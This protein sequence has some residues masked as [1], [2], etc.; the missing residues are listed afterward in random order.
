MAALIPHSSMPGIISP[1][2]PSQA[3]A[4]ALAM[5]YQL[6]QSQ[7]WP[8]QRVLEQQCLQMQSLFRHAWHTVPFYRQRLEQAGIGPETPLDPEVIRRIPVLSRSEVQQAGQAM[9]SSALPAAHGESRPVQTSG[10]TGRPVRLAGTRL[11]EFFWLAFTLRDHL[12]HKRD[13]SLKLAAIRFIKDNKAMAPRGLARKGWGPSTDTVF[14]TGPSALLNVSSNLG[15]QLAWLTEQKP[16]YLLTFPTN[17]LALARRCS[18]EGRVL[19]TLREV[20][21]VGE[22][23]SDSLRQAC[24]QAWDVPLVDFYTSNEAGYLALQCPGHSHYHVQAENVYLE[25]I[26]ADGRPCEPGETGQVVITN[27]NN[28]A[29]PLIRYALG[30]QAR[31]GRACPCGRGLPVIEEILGRQ[32]N[33]LVLPDGETHWPS[34]GYYRFDEIADIRQFQ[35]VQLNTRQVEV[36][37]VTASPLGP[38]Q[39][40]Q[41]KQVI[42][43]HLGYP[44][45]ILLVYRDEIPRGPGGKYEEFISRVADA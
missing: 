2:I 25:I 34:F 7:W 36:R 18:A 17:L 20:R 29:T 23:V 6:E 31:P 26:N 30:D 40:E 22:P 37:L 5:Q 24:R 28:F 44:F 43:E 3:G 9:H 16:G 14:R 41:L 4:M 8:P 1:A 45:E 15:E 10:S 12:W 11:T 39:E 19:P 38:Q 27:L 32:R 35:A 21:T 42:T 13:L 33:M